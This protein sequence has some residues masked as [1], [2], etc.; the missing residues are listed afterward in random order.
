M[1]AGNCPTRRSLDRSGRAAQSVAE[2]TL[3]ERAC[4]RIPDLCHR[5]ANCACFHVDAIR[6]GLELCATGA[7][8]RGERA[9][10]RPDH[11]SEA[12]I[13]GGARQ[14]VATDPAPSAGHDVGVAQHDEDRFQKLERNALSPGNLTSRQRAPA[15]GNQQ[16]GTQGVFG[17]LR[18][19]C[20]FELS[21]P[22]LDRD[23]LHVD[24]GAIQM[25]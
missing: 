8:D 14:P 19:H 25:D 22:D 9:V 10:D 18:Q 3:I 16:H 6:A 23:Y 13:S 15:F 24:L 1:R 12:D 21:E 7:S 4:D 5:P 17:F 2:G 11:F 20:L